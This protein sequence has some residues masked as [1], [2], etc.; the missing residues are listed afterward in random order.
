MGSKLAGLKHLKSIHIDNAGLQDDSLAVFGK[1]PKIERLSLQGNAFT[2]KGLEYLQ[3]CN[4][5][6]VLWVGLG[7]SKFTDKG[8]LSMRKLDNLKTFGFQQSP[9]SPA[10]VAAFEDSGV[11]LIHPTQL[12]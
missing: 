10:T 9:V 7:K 8:I 5:L 1:L 12:N 6:Q 3:D 2:D 11:E 4:S